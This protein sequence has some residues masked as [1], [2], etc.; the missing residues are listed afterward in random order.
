MI[1]KKA[2]AHISAVLLLLGLVSCA[3][4]VVTDM[5]T[6]EFA[7]TSPDS[8]RLFRYGQPV[9]SQ[10]RAIGEVKVVDN[11]LSTGGTYER[12]LQMAVEATA[13]NGGNGLV[14]T[15]HRTPDLASTIHR[16]WGTMLRIPDEGMQA[17]AAADSMVTRKDSVTVS[18]REYEAF[19][20]YQAEREEYQARL[21]AAI[22]RRDSILNKAPRNVLR[23]SA[24]PSWLASKYQLGNHL[25]KSRCGYDLAVDYD[26]VWRSCLGFGINYLHNYTSFYEGVKT[27]INYIGPSV[28][29]CYPFGKFRYDLALGFGYCY[30]TESSSFHSYKEGKIAPLMRVGLEYQLMSHMALGVQLDI[31][32]MHMDKPEGVEL[33]KGEFY[34][35]QRGGLMAGVRIYL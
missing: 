35:I 3:P 24:G 19:L 33:E 8:V 6:T 10:T 4:K 20:R 29:L 16:I 34:G 31:Y 15:K 7:P 13:Q 22:N 5:F 23:I 18:Y 11:G 27:R 9:P 32:S 1:I 26:H 21:Q 12:V 25:Y 2:I 28:V 30:Y 14:I 17:L